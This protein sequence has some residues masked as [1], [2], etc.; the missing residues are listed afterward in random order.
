[1]DYTHLKINMKINLDRERGREGEEGGE[2]E[3]D[4]VPTRSPPPHQS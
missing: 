2:E 1:L 3:E 4:L